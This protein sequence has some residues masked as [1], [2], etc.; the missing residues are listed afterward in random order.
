MDRACLGLA[1]DGLMLSAWFFG[2]PMGLVRV[3]IVPTVTLQ[4]PS[5]KDLGNLCPYV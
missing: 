5:Q 2:W 1:L 4:F 3:N